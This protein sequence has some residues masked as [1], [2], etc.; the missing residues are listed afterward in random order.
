MRSRFY[1]L[2]VNAWTECNFPTWL[3][4]TANFS[5]TLYV[6]HFPLLALGLSL[7]LGRPELTCYFRH[8]GVSRRY[9]D[10]CRGGHRQPPAGG[11]FDV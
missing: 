6:I 2:L 11:R 1:L 9:P 10:A 4:A 5:Y 3:R 8:R 7:A